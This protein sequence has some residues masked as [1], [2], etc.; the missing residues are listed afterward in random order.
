M[1]GLTG[2]GAQSIS[3]GQRGGRDHRPRPPLPTVRRRSHPPHKR[4]QLRL[5]VQD[6]LAAQCAIAPGD[7]MTREPGEP[8]VRL[9]CFL[10]LRQ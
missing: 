6:L 9:R 5:P 2:R 10:D 1:C 8:G 7:R 4:T 3:S